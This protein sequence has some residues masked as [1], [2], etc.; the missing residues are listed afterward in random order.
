[1]PTRLNTY[2]CS[3]SDDD[4]VNVIFLNF[5]SK[6]CDYYEEFDKQC[7]RHRKCVVYTLT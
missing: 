3:K 6:I 7:A 2:G 5:F 1:M 4:D